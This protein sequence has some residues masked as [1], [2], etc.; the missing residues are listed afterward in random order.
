MLEKDYTQMVKRLTRTSNLGL[1]EYVQKMRRKKNIRR[2]ALAGVEF[3]K[4][5]IVALERGAII[6]SPKILEL[7]AQ[8]LGVPVSDLLDRDR[9]L[10]AAIDMQALREDLGYRHKYALMLIRGEKLNEVTEVCESIEHSVQLYG[11][12]LPDI[13]RQSVPY[14][15]GRTY[16]ASAAPNKALP[17]LEEAL[18]FVDG[19]EEARARTLNLIGVA[20]FELHQPWRAL[21]YYRI[22]EEIVLAKGIR[23][24]NY[25]LSL[26][27]NLANTYWATNQPELSIEVYRGHLLPLIQNLINPLDEARVYWGM[28]MSYGQLDDQV[29]AIGC[30]W[31]AL[32]IYET[33]NIGLSEAADVC[34]FL[35][36]TLTK[37][38]R[39]NEAT[40]AL[41]RCEHL[42]GDVEQP[43]TLSYMHQAYAVIALRHERPNEAIEHA[44]KS[45]YFARLQYERSLREESG[46][47]NSTWQNP[48]RPYAEA[49][50][51]HALVEVE[52]GNKEAA[53]AL[54]EAAVA[55]LQP[56]G[57]DEV[58]YKIY[59]SY[60]DTLIKWGEFKKA[61]HHYKIAA[62]L[63]N[64]TRRT[65][66]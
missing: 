36:E 10:T 6:P 28:A 65:I 40:E 38:K 26:Y 52:R 31:K 13:V 50:H 53:N 21:H 22:C 37:G 18:R 29:R 54:F 25:E 41:Q 15:R 60:A 19:N 1:G 48:G 14:L 23:D 58:S 64:S 35:A 42:L 8:R 46:I 45:V 3:S 34:L 43:I 61:A 24:M 56:S 30:C 16:I 33:N 47:T 17:H 27:R 62:E 32:N 49:L 51:T 39:Y 59:F 55:L 11:D 12:M 5:F 4:S 63:Q 9:D 44:V 20:Y 2:E 66:A 7:F 57:F